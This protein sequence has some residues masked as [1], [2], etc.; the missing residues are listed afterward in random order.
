MNDARQAV[1]MQH[2]FIA[3][4]DLRL[5]NHAKAIENY[6]ESDREFANLP[7]PRAGSLAV[8]RMRA[9]VQGRLGDARL[10]SGQP[11]AANEHY[12]KALAERL[13]LLRPDSET[14]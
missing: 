10:R 6:L 4:A 12:K 8:R 9:E 13:E 14:G 1:A 5:G 3:F 7:R 11:D 2:G